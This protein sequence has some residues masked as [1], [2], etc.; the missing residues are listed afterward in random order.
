MSTG[1]A[2]LLAFVA[3]VVY[4][5]PSLIAAF[6]HVRNFGT[7]IVVNL[8]FGWTVIGWVVALA[9]ACGAEREVH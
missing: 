1:V 2:F 9:I 6:R 3:V 7:I 5:V 4:F 8:F